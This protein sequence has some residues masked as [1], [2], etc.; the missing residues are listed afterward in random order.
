MLG[1][2]LLRLRLRELK[3]SKG[4]IS[5]ALCYVIPIA[6]AIMLIVSAV[7]ITGGHIGNNTFEEIEAQKIIDTTVSASPPGDEIEITANVEEQV[8]YTHW[9][10]SGVSIK[11]NSDPEVL[12]EIEKDT[13]NVTL[14]FPEPEGSCPGPNSTYIWHGD[15]D[16]PP[17][18]PIVCYYGGGR[19]DNAAE[20][21]KYTPD[22]DGEYIGMAEFYIEDVFGTMPEDIGN[23]EQTLTVEGYFLN[24]DTFSVQCSITMEYG[25][26]YVGDGG[27]YST[28]QAAI[29]DDATTG[30]TVYVYEGEY[31]ERVTINKNVRWCLST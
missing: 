3:N 6:V 31:H 22:Y 23:G 27:D 15:E 12:M 19:P 28:I 4:S 18:H 24:K 21:V 17:L 25:D 5:N 14:T 11:V 8:W 13:F 10:Y 29:N 2:K 20:C 16:V 7:F 9:R 1:T 30:K 26:Y